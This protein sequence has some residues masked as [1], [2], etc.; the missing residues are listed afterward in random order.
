MGKT[1][2]EG[3][4]ARR[5]PTGARER[6][7]DRLPRWHGAQ[8][9][10]GPRRWRGLRRRPVQSCAPPRTRSQ[11]KPSAHSGIIAHSFPR[12]PH[13]PLRSR[14]V[15]RMEAEEPGAPPPPPASAISPGGRRPCP[16]K[17]RGRPHLPSRPWR[18]GA[19]GRLE[20]PGVHTDGGAVRPGRMELGV[21]GC[22]DRVEG[23]RVELVERDGRAWGTLGWKELG[24]RGLSGP[25]LAGERDGPAW[26]EGAG[27]CGPCQGTPS[28]W[29]AGEWPAPHRGPATH[30]G[31]PCRSRSSSP[32]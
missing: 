30:L 29:A 25:G 28:P 2:P 9:A 32:R 4:P 7:L 18:T 10:E 26:M 1:G 22:R 11:G 31:T 3:K 14:G 16:F 24:A 6:N 13:P 12:H 21:L 5:K 20:G 15:L 19:L 8:E 23:S 27:G 17:N